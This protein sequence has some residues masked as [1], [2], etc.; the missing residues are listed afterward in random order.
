MNAISKWPGPGEMP[1]L[2]LIGW[3]SSQTRY[4]SQSL[5]TEG[6]TFVLMASQPFQRFAANCLSLLHFP[7]SFDPRPTRQHGI[8]SQKWCNVRGFDRG[9]D[10]TTTYLDFHMHSNVR[11][12][13]PYQTTR[14]G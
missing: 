6:F 13:V 5:T 14:L 3:Q 7:L 11:A 9:I 2:P 8:S 1:V 10:S 4:S 12:R